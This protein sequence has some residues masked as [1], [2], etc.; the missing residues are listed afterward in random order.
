M[1]RSTKLITLCVAL[2]LCAGAASRCVA[3]EAKKT[4]WKVSGQLEEAC[5]CNAA[6][7]CWFGSKPTMA[8]CGGYQVLFIDR[9]RYSGV[10]LNGLAIANTVQSPDGKTMMESFG[11]WNEQ[12]RHALLEIAK[13]VLPTGSSKKQEV[14]YVAITRAMEGKQHKITVGQHGSFN[15]QLL[16]GGLG[17]AP[18]IIN[19]PGADP[20]HASYLQGQT[21][22]LIY[23]DAGQN[24]NLKDSN[25]MLA[26]FSLTSEQYE[27][28][29]AGLAQKMA[30][31][32]KDKK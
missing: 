9:G 6:C 18:K 13:A 3:G 12:Q 21:S 16:E 11:D 30:A 4:S 7:P 23:T 26:D 28:Y 29:S 14:R 2:V 8:N 20:L 10:S 15:G 24:W 25:Y 17:G 31:M 22:K 5:T 27:R 19:P 32:C 1:N